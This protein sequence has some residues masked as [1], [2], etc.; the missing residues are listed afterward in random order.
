MEIFALFFSGT[1]KRKCWFSPRRALVFLD[2]KLA[3]IPSEKMKSVGMIIPNIWKIIQM[4]QSRK[5]QENVQQIVGVGS[6][7]WII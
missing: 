5:S 4:F 2:K 7:S 3:A 1:S 6:P